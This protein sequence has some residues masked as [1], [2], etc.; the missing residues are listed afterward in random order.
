MHRWL[1]LGH[2]PAVKSCG[3]PRQSLS[4]ERR[5]VGQGNVCRCPRRRPR[6]D[7][8]VHRRCRRRRQHKWWRPSSPGSAAHVAPRRG[9]HKAYTMPRHQCA[10]S[11]ALPAE[12]STPRRDRYRAAASGVCTHTQIWR[13]AV[14]AVFTSFRAHRS[15]TMG[16]RL[17]LTEA[18]GTQGPLYSRIL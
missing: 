10:L 13:T 15:R 14:W 1:R 8:L 18:T 9:S 2:S 17:G 12:S 5:V 16:R 4:S 6:P 7:S 3:C 11:S